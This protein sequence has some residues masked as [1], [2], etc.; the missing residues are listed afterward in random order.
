MVF[1]MPGES[2]DPRWTLGDGIGE[3]LRNQG[4]SRREAGKRTGELLERCGLSLEY[5]GRY[6]HQVSGGQCQRAALARALAAGPKVLVCDEITSALDVTVQKQILEL[7]LKLKED[8][9]LSFLFISHDL[10]LVQAFCDR[11]LV[12]RQGKLVEE[13]ETEAVIRHPAAEYTK[14]LIDSVL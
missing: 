5:A 2:F 6:P 10:A 3:S 14:Q 9:Q 13:G 11:V 7:L 4:L 8:E 1:Q 12:L